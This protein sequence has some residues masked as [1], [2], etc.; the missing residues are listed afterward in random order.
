MSQSP[1]VDGS[2]TQH[3]YQPLVHTTAP[4]AATGSSSHG[5]PKFN[6]RAAIGIGTTLIVAAVL[7]MIMNGIELMH[8]GALWGCWTR[9]LGRSSGQYVRQRRFFSDLSTLR[10]K[11]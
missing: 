4:A 6:R 7:G 11:K 2:V 3:V 9:F 1:N 10:S 8:P 5:V